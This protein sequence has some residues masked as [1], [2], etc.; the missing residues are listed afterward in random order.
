MLEEVQ[1]I[2][3]DVPR[4]ADFRTLPAPVSYFGFFAVGCMFVMV[5]MGVIFSWMN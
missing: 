4:K 3:G 2:E 1:R 5:A